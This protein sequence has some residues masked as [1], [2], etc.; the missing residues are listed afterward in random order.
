MTTYVSDGHT[1]PP[2]FNLIRIGTMIR[3]LQHEDVVEP[4]SDSI[5]LGIWYEDKN[6]YKR[7]FP[8]LAAAVEWC[9]AEKADVTAI[10][11]ELARPYLYADSIGICFNWLSGVERFRCSMNGINHYRVVVSSRGEPVS[12]TKGREA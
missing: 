8:T 9:G 2:D 7:S 12:F 6:V 5:V 1:V 11:I 3:R 10:Q 4:F